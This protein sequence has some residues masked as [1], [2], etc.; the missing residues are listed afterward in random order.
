MAEVFI[1]ADLSSPLNCMSFPP[2]WVQAPESTV[3]IN[4]SQIA[5]I[6][7]LPQQEEGQRA[8]SALLLQPLASSAWRQ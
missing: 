4:S 5:P 7:P 3:K 2:G 6:R 1:E 8:A